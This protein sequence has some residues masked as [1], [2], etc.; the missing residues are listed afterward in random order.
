M[1]YLQNQARFG[2]ADQ[3]KAEHD[4]KMF[5]E[6]AERLAKEEEEED[7]RRFMARMKK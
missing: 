2:V 7:K 6:S 1:E 4:E 5:M 3:I